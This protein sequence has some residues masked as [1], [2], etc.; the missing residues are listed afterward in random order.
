MLFL[1][2]VLLL[3]QLAHA[4]NM[5]LQLKDDTHLSDFFSMNPSFLAHFDKYHSFGSFQAL[6]GDIP[7]SLVYALA[8]NLLVSGKRR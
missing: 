3:L 2:P 4:R 5:I 8:K 6:A 1:L 7:S